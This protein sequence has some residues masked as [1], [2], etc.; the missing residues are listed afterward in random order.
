MSQISKTLRTDGDA[1]YTFP[2]DQDA[3][4]R[5]LGQEEIDA[6]RQVIESGTLTST[7]GTWVKQ[8]EGAVSAALGSRFA[9]ATNSGTS[10][11]HAAI[12]AID[13]EP[14]DEII[15]TPITDMGALT[16][17]L[18]QSAV[19]VFADV[20][21]TTGNL[22]AQTIQERISERTRGIVVTHLFGKTCEM[23]EIMALANRHKIP[24][25]EDCAQS[26]LAS[27]NHHFAGTLGAIGCFSLQQGKHI[28]AGE[29]GFVVTDNDD[30]ARRMF[31]FI[32]KAWGYGDPSPDHYFLAL[33][34]RLTELQGAVAVAQLQ[35]L[36]PGVEQ[37][38]RLADE[39]TSQLEGTPGLQLPTSSP[40]SRHSYWRYCLHV[41]PEVV[42]GGTHAL[43]E[44]LRTSGIFAAPGY[45]QKPAFETEI[46]REQRTFGRS[47]FPFSM[48]RPE[49][50]E[51]P[52][53]A[54]A[55][56]Y[57]ALARMLVLPWNEKLT[58]E[59]V[60]YLAEAVRHAVRALQS[61]AEERQVVAVGTTS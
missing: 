48:A 52:R 34:S 3:S 41:D 15:T 60:A 27:S 59:D 11:I 49:A 1:P 14:G 21:P 51:Y 10:A 8:F 28:T 50:V 56:T 25:I 54:F 24:V 42:P 43:A 13:P 32:N 29:G 36:A 55:G 19:P 2:S 4:G 20:D 23:N 18:Y 40:A 44:R 45:I 47:R 58:F 53:D 12:A 26:Y 31:L 57:E 61:G 30:F 17:I 22:T 9:Y 7:K 5:S 39:L 33:N 37:R 16:P 6:L 38:I 46:F 35:K